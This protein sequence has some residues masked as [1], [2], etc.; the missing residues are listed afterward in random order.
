MLLCSITKRRFPE[1]KW[2][3]FDRLEEEKAIIERLKM[4]QKLLQGYRLGVKE[5]DG[6]V[7][8]SV[9]PDNAIDY[10]SVVD[11][12]TDDGFVYKVYYLY[13]DQ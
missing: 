1:G 2:P 9:I 10:R 11:R 7:D 5:T 13:K 4:A 3:V 12:Y 8:S 6:F